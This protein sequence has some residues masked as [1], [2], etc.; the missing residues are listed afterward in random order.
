[1]DKRSLLKNKQL[2]RFKL[3]SNY[4]GKTQNVT[5]KKLKNRKAQIPREKEVEIEVEEEDEEESSNQEETLLM[6]DSN[7]ASCEVRADEN[8]EEEANA[9][10]LRTK[11][12]LN[13]SPSAR[14]DTG[15]ED[16]NLE[17]DDLYRLISGQM[18][19]YDKFKRVAPPEKEFFLGERKVERL[20]IE[21]LTHENQKLAIMVKNVSK[22]K[23]ELKM[24]LAK[25]LK[26]L[27]KIRHKCDVVSAEYMQIMSERDVVHKEIE[28]LQEKLSKYEEEKRRNETF[29][30]AS[31]VKFY[32]SKFLNGQNRSSVLS[33]KLDSLEMIDALKYQ[34]DS[35]SKQRDEAISQVFYYQNKHAL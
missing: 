1:M 22:E 2:K 14:I 32:E 15:H 19:S 29:D 28:A 10:F 4:S 9:S 31:K 21:K 30:A 13:Q 7:E 23:E 35:V 3:N 8:E 27:Q 25:R 12:M 26:E 6:S 24:E 34:L 17:K 16:E 5:S 11:A 20:E 33:E 18:K